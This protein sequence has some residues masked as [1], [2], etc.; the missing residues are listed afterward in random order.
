MSV[1]VTILLY[2]FGLDAAT[3]KLNFKCDECDSSTS[4]KSG[5]LIYSSKYVVPTKNTNVKHVTIDNSIPTGTS[6][7]QY[8]S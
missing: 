4:N 5:N 2:V 7:P 8:S 3:G 1:I 6:D